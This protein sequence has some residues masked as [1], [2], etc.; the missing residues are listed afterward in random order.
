MEVC[1]EGEKGGHIGE[2]KRESKEGVRK[3]ARIIGSTE[4]E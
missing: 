4:N 2:S 3:S 1:S